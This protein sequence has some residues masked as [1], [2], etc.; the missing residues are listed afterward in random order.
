MC[1]LSFV[2]ETYSRISKKSYR[3]PQ[4]PNR[5]DLEPTWRGRVLSSQPYAN[6]PTQKTRF[7]LLYGTS[8]ASSTAS[9]GPYL[10]AA[11]L[12]TLGGSMHLWCYC[13]VHTYTNTPW[14]HALALFF[15]CFGPRLDPFWDQSQLVRDRLKTCSQ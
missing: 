10:R 9:H 5:V 4:T 13:C 7:L 2:P 8:C 3:Q 1:H 14:G 15:C 11:T 12:L 6:N